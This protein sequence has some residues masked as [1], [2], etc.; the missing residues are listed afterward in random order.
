MWTHRLQQKRREMKSARR[1]R[2]SEPSFFCLFDISINGVPTRLSLV[3]RKYKKREQHHL[4]ATH[5]AEEFRGLDR[6]CWLYSAYVSRVGVLP[7]PACDGSGTPGGEGL[8][9]DEMGWCGMNFLLSFFPLPPPLTVRKEKRHEQAPKR[10]V[11]VRVIEESM[12]KTRALHANPICLWVGVGV[13]VRERQR[14]IM[15]K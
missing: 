10:K 4:K 2:P 13:C 9:W 15:P 14:K 7:G 5:E 11:K 6:C 12:N 3:H 1:T 8:Q